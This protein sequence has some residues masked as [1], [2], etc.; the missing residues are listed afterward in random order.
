MESYESSLADVKG[1]GGNKK[2]E[3]NIEHNFAAFKPGDFRLEWMK[4]K[5]AE[6]G[7]VMWQNE[8]WDCTKAEV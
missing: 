3:T 4:L 2:E 8:K 6:T 1:T 5:N 7:Q